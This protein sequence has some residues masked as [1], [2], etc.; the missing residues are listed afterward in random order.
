[1]IES[2]YELRRK[3]AKIDKQ[4]PKPPFHAHFSVD[5]QGFFSCGDTLLAPEEA[6]RLARWMYKFYCED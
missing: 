6:E 4:L 5:N 3:L 2:Y 1:M